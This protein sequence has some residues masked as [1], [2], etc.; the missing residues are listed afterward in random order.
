[1]ESVVNNTVAAYYKNKK[2]F[3]T[4]HTGFKGAWLITWLHLLGANIKGY[5]L[6]PEDGKGLF[7]NISGKFEFKNIIADIRNKERLETEILNFQP[8][9]IF[10]LAAQALVRRSYEIPAETFEVNV[11]GTANVLEV[12]DKLS[13]KCTIIVVTTDKVY[14]NKESDYYYKEDD[15]L[16]GYDPYSASKAAAEIVVSSFR[17]AFFSVEKYETHQ[18]SVASV[19][20][21]NVIGGGDWNKDRIIPDIIRSLTA[22]QPVEVRNPFAVRPWQHVLEPISGY[23]LTGMLLDMNI[24][25]FTGTYNFGPLPDDHLPVHVLV[26]TAIDCW[27]SGN[28]IDKSDKTQPHEAGLL[29]LDISKAQKELQWQPRLKS[30]EAIQWT[31]DWYRQNKQS[32]FDY[33]VDQI[34]NYQQK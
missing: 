21:G 15:V 16:G 28:W 14:E 5:S 8:D 27:G 17:N 2:V 13:N 33:T 34:K 22:G 9:F 31:I 1:M 26:E 6:E 18:K 7:N 4:G 23:L 20:A 29:K 10:H 30:K 32:A 3:V 12:A 25:K 11:T 24:N 19:R